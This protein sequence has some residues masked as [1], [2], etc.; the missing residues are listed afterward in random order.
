MSPEVYRI[1]TLERHWGSD[2]YEKWLS[3]ALQAQLPTA[4]AGEPG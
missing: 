1:L 4:A 2:R 3:A